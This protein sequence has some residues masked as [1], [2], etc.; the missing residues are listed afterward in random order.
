VIFQ[1]LWQILSQ[2]GIESP[3]VDAALKNIDVKELAHSAAWLAES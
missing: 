2:T 3:W 1:S